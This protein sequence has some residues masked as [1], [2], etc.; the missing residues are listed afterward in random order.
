MVPNSVEVMCSNEKETGA[1]VG[2]T[3]CIARLEDKAQAQASAPPPVLPPKRLAYADAAIAAATPLG[4]VDDASKT[5]RH[6]VST[7]KSPE[8]VVQTSDVPSIDATETH[9]PVKNTETAA[10]DASPANI[11]SPN[12]SRAKRVAQAAVRRSELVTMEAESLV[13]MHLEENI[14]SDLSKCSEQVAARQD[15]L[16][17]NR[18]ATAHLLDNLEDFRCKKADEIAQL[19]ERSASIDK[20]LSSNRGYHKQCSQLAAEVG[21]SLATTTKERTDVATI[22]GRMEVEL[23]QAQDRYHKQA[24]VCNALKADLTTH[25]AQ[26]SPIIAK[27]TL[28]VAHRTAEAKAT[29]LNAEI[30]S[31]QLTA[32][33]RRYDE[34]RGTS[35]DLR[36]LD[37]KQERAEETATEIDALMA[38]IAEDEEMVSNPLETKRLTRIPRPRKGVDCSLMDAC[39]CYVFAAL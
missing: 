4:K 12:A 39:D 33:Q 31:A 7:A 3:A 34:I 5:S 11:A 22:M 10:T 30:W 23:G 32:I 1:G 17:V 35:T 37:A 28:D 38:Q 2:V 16:L 14:A 25:E 29:S 27:A 6:G 13:L 20:V 24:A 19:M 18:G 26:I 21:A 9:T 36:S 15:A 8:Y